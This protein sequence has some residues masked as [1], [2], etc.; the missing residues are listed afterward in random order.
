M[1][2]LRIMQEHSYNFSEKRTWFLSKEKQWV[3]P[4]KKDVASELDFEKH[5]QYNC[6]SMNKEKVSWEE[7]GT[8]QY[9]F[10]L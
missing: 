10:Y 3:K 1:H 7:Y 5:F 2:G 9:I 4:I 8:K 6:L